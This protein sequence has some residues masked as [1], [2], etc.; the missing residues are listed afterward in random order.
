MLP[1]AGDPDVILLGDFNSYAKEDPV[2]TL[3]GGGFTDLETLF[4]GAGAYSY[5]FD[6]QLGHLDYGFASAS[7]LPQIT[8]TDA[9]H[10]NADEVDLFDYNDEILDSPGEATFEEKPDGS[11]L[12]PPRVVFQPMSPY[13]A[14]DHDPVLVGLF[15]VA[16]LAITK[17]DGVTTAVPGGS[18][19]YTITASNAG[20]DPVSGGTVADTFPAILT[21]TWTCV[22]AGGGTCTAAGAGNLSDTVNLPAGG[23]VTYTASCAVSAAA[24]GTLVNTATVSSAVGDPNAGNNSA[25]DTDTLT[26]QADLAVTKT[27]G[28]TTATAGGPVT[29][30][31]TASNSGPSDAPGAT[32]ADTFPA[33]LTCT[34]TCVGA[35]GGTCTAAGAGNLGDT[36]NLPA[37]G[38]VTYTASCTLSA[39]ATGTLTNTA[40][41]AAPGGVTDPA[42]GNDSA[43]DVDTVTAQA[44]LVVT[45]TDGVTT[46]TAGGP[47]TY[48]I[49]A[50]NPGPSDAPGATVADTFPASLTCTWT[51][52]GA[53]GGTCTAAGAGNISDSV[54]LPAGGSVTYTASCTLSAAATG[55]L[56]NTATVTAPG[57]VTDPVPGNNNATDSD[58]VAA[59]PS[60][61]VSGTKTASGTFAVGG[62]VTYTVTLT[63][64]GSG[65]QGDNP[66]DEFTDVL[67]PTL[68]LVSATASSGTAVASTGTNTVTWNGSIP[69]GGG[70]V[71]I[72]ITATILPSAAGMTVSNQGAIHFDA[73]GNGTNEASAVTDDPAAGGSGDP[74]S[75]V[76]ADAP[77]VVE[78]P[79]LDWR[80]L[81]ALAALLA[82]LGAWRLRR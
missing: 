44:D 28:V 15:Q 60:A 2:T 5:L 3:I 6:G 72:T 34:W 12:V 78:I 71:T 63:N 8:G 53:G 43:T 45:K 35:G 70:S 65:A 21:C 37:G 13:R 79:T 19:T 67:P 9:W 32:V 17:T 57:G 23:S 82:A 24:T 49:T 81:L 50:S 68:A 69:A 80:G 61:D 38:S 42:P 30:T 26:P 75:F 16:D 20:P 10:I 29:Y 66:G 40:T 7:L 46:A 18:V 59:A 4:H 56:S 64:T 22:G 76:V 58:T 48:T 73:D 55:T 62:T 25:T 27:D 39:A 1:A 33:A 52:V 51:C 31:I 77:A 11:A 54:N 74:T 36:V 41:V 47:V 14:S